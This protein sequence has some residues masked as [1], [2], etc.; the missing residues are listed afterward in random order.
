MEGTA[1]K[2]NISNER[3]I[4]Q[5]MEGKSGNGRIKEKENQG[6]IIKER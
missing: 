3:K 4:K 5:G 6:K 1:G 2:G